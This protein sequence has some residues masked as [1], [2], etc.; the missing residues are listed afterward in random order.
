MIKVRKINENDPFLIEKWINS[1][2]Q[3]AGKTNV[4]FWL[5]QDR[6][7]C[8]VIEDEIGVIFYV[9]GENVLR[10]HIQ[11]APASESER[12]KK[13][14]DEFASHIRESARPTYR[15]IIFE[16][17]FAPLIRFLHKRG[18]RA[19]KEENVIDL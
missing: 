7:N 13:A 3:H 14:L 4:D 19:S 17:T 18:Y 11:F 12:T 6:T 9:R 8:F 2:P 10:L 16:S 15:Q 5:P 1:D